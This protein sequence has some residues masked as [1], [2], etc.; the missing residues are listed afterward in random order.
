[1]KYTIYTDNNI[2]DGSP[3]HVIGAIMHTV[4]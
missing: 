2:S 3:K 1:M 4:V